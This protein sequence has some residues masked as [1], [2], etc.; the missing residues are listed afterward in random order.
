VSLLL[1]SHRTKRFLRACRTA[2]HLTRSH[3]RMYAL[4]RLHANQ[5][6][7]ASK[8]TAA[9]ELTHLR[10][11]ANFM[12]HNVCS[13]IVFACEVTCG[14]TG[15]SVAPC[16]RQQVEHLDTLSRTKKT[17]TDNKILCFIQSSLAEPVHGG[18][19]QFLLHISFL[20]M[21]N[22]YYR[23]CRVKMVQVPGNNVTNDGP[24][25]HKASIQ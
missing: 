20:L 13:E 12:R 5:H 21:M 3:K 10:N 23:V 18:M 15:I 22:S 9:V 17:L 16:S 11:D 25:G 24:R 7:H 2:S 4:Q 8:R 14:D 6:G 19:L 1:L